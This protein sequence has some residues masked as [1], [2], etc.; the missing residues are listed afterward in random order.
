MKSDGT[1]SWSLNAGDFYVRG[2]L[3]KMLPA[4]AYA[5]IAEL[6]I[7]FSEFDEDHPDVFVREHRDI[8]DT[9]WD[10]PVVQNIIVNY[11]CFDEWLL[12][13]WQL[14]LRGGEGL[15]KAY[16]RSEVQPDNHIMCYEDGELISPNTLTNVF[17]RFEEKHGIKKIRYHDLRHS[18]ASILYANG[19]DLMTIQEVLGHTQLTTT[20]LYT[21]KIDDKKKYALA[22]MHNQFLGAQSQEMEKKE[23]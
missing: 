13:T 17:R 11:Y 1:V 22:H 4:N 20:L 7:L 19:T 10:A 16:E 23:N 3:L 15:Q 12:G 18:C 14:F 21:H 8:L 5:N 2:M 6:K 9:L